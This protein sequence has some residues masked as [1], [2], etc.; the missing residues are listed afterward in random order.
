MNWF[1]TF[2]VPLFLARSFLFLLSLIFA[3]YGELQTLWTS[4]GALSKAA[5]RSCCM[6]AAKH[7]T[8]L[9][10]RSDIRSPY[11]VDRRGATPFGGTPFGYVSIVLPKISWK[12]SHRH[13]GTSATPRQCRV[14]AAIMA[15]CYT[16]GSRRAG[17]FCWVC[18][19]RK[20]D[21]LLLANYQLIFLFLWI[22]I[23]FNW[24]TFRRE[25]G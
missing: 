4:L 11:P 6:K 18:G 10:S 9:R 20:V 15:L 22:S 8:V 23:F 13:A 19:Q 5:I 17:L 25:K 24:S 1:N 7:R 14:L 3:F 16:I 12:R 2:L 21:R